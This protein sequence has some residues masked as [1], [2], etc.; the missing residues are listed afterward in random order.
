MA[1]M[2]EELEI[3]G[4]FRGEIVPEAR[5]QLGCGS[6]GELKINSQEVLM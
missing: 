4:V 3:G 1:V 6:I 2:K 5:C